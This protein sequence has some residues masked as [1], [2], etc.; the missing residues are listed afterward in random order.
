MSDFTTEWKETKVVMSVNEFDKYREAE[1]A[2]KERKTYTIWIDS[3]KYGEN[4]VYSTVGESEV[5]KELTDRITKLTSENYD[6]RN[7]KK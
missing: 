6:L 1:R 3:G 7:P 2:I 5:I 4:K